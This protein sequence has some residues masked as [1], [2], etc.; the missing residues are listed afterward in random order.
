VDQR[1]AQEAA[2]VDEWR[3]DQ[4][5]KSEVVELPKYTPERN[6]DEYLSGDGKANRKADGLP[7][8][9]E[10]LTGKLRRLRQ[11]LSKLPARIASSFQHKYIHDAAGPEPILT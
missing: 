10:G 4:G 5:E 8:D 9:R 2:V 7:K 6:A 1:S 11:K 3:A